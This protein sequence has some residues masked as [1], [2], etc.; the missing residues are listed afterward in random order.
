ME[1]IKESA[2]IYFSFSIYGYPHITLLQYTYCLSVR[3]SFILQF[4]IYLNK[5]NFQPFTSSF[6]APW[7]GGGNFQI[8]FLICILLVCLSGKIN[9]YFLVVLSS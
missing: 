4:C 3:R 1:P 6:L 9:K 2:S 7:G 8:I 5:F